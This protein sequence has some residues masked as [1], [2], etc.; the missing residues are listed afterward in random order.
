MFIPII[1]LQSSIWF[2]Y[3]CLS[4]CV[5]PVALLAVASWCNDLH[6]QFKVSIDFGLWFKHV[7]RVS[8]RR[9]PGVARGR[10]VYSSPGTRLTEWAASP[11]NC[12]R[13]VDSGVLTAP[14]CQ[15]YRTVS[16]LEWEFV[17]CHRRRSAEGA[18]AF[19]KPVFEGLLGECLP[20][21]TNEAIEPPRAVN[22]LLLHTRAFWMHI[23]TTSANPGTHSSG[24]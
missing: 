13:G 5:V 19:E 4:Q 7:R 11:V 15:R 14:Q 3:A 9:K 20:S 18:P 22:E 8:P 16:A 1:G 6:L 17:H 2:V 12:K 10:Q 24:V 21:R 23:K